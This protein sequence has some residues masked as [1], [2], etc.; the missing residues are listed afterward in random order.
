MFTPLRWT[1]KW[2]VCCWLCCCACTETNKDTEGSDSD[3]LDSDTSEQTASSDD[4]EQDTT[5]QITMIGTAEDRT[6]FEYVF[7]G[8]VDETVW[9]K[10]LYTFDGNG[11]ILSPDQVVAG[12]DYVTLRI[13][14]LEEEQEGRLYASGQLQTNR[15]FS[16]GTFTARMRSPIPS[17]TVSSVFVMNPWEAGHW[18]HKEIDIEFLGKDRRAVQYAVHRF[19]ADT[20]SGGGDPYIQSLDFDIGDAFHEYAI[21]WRPDLI[22]WRVDGEAVYTYDQNIPDEP[23]NL[24][25]N[26]W[27]PD[28]DTSWSADWVGEFDEADLPSVTEYE[29]IRYEPLVTR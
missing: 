21:V 10:G 3:P 9:I 18:L 14:K 15:L 13:D 20:E 17:G 19:Y 25:V 23:M 8:E 16:Y 24:F 7:D 12:D 22:E 4:T 6:P 27:L 11:T 26:F 5:P 1:M 28:P 29:W 2:T